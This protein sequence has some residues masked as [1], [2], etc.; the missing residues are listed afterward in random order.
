MVVANDI[1]ILNSIKQ[2]HGI[3]ADDTSFDYE[4]IMHINGEL[5]TMTQLGVGP[6]EGFSITSAENTWGE[7]LGIRK[8]LNAV[9]NDVYLRVR[10]VFDP[11]QNASLI[12]SMERRIQEY[13]W[14]I[15]SWHNPVAATPTETL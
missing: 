2:M 14:R 6:Q 12:A 7:L 11:P 5:M 4:L 9:F 1:S 10:L 15:E 3:A 8:D 13:D